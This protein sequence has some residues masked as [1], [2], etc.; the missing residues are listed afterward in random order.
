MYGE[1]N[2]AKP[3][4][5]IVGLGLV[6]GSIG[7]ALHQVKTDFEIVGHDKEPAVANQARK[8]GAVD[9]V[10]WN[11]IAACEQ[12]DVVF[13]ATPVLAIKDTLTV[14]APDLKP[15]A[16]V[17]DTT[18]TKQ[19]VMH[20]AE[21]ILPTKVSFIGGDPL[22]GAP[23][24]GLDGASAE[25]FRN[26]LYCLTPLAS[27]Q[28]DSVQLLADLVTLI[29][30]R[31]YFIDAVEHDGL[32]AGIDHLPFVLSMALLHSVS[33]SAAWRDIINMVTYDFRQATALTEVDPAIHRDICLANSAG[34]VRW[35][36]AAIESLTALRTAVAAED[37]EAVERLFSQVHA[38]RDELLRG[39]RQDGQLAEEL[40]RMNKNRL[41]QMFLGSVGRTS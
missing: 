10:E 17:T 12:A 16:I 39:P 32:M 19:Q 5:T 40:D 38:A 37:A 22:V 4:I 35:I 14:I 26:A 33:S 24:T 29:G 31:P 9:R 11:L 28:P 7:L 6:G 3:R 34:V 2:M 23:Q 41:R 20:W 27:A 8:R 18:T 30:A 25:L 36:D 15:G 1:G 21:E 13:L